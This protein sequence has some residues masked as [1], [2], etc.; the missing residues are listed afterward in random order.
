ML[1][2]LTFADRSSRDHGPRWTVSD[3]IVIGMIK[4][5]LETNQECAEGKLKPGSNTLCTPQLTLRYSL[6]SMVSH[7]TSRTS[8]KIGPNAGGRNQKL[9]HAVELQI[10]AGPAGVSRITGRL[11]TQP[12]AIIP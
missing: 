12:P 2:S 10:D 8:T 5:E 9:Q 11:F 6:S 7:E 1:S 3:E 4:A